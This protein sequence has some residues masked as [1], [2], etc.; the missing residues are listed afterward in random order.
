MPCSSLRFSPLNLSIKKRF[1]N[2]SENEFRV[3]IDCVV[4]ARITTGAVVVC[5]AAIEA[6]V[7][8]VL[9]RELQILPRPKRDVC[10]ITR[11]SR[12]PIGAAAHRGWRVQPRIDGAAGIEPTECA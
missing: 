8:D 11:A 6:C 10:D 4:R 7:S 2:A 9:R 5:R 3:Q 12:I 1:K